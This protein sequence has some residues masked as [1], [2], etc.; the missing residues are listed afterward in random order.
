MLTAWRRG[1]VL[2]LTRNPNYWDAGKPYLDKIIAKI[3]PQSTSRRNYIKG[4]VAAGAV[5]SSSA[6]LFR[7]STVHGQPAAGAVER[8]ITA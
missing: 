3:M 5:A 7:G 1:D 4:V 6:Y 8:L 2:E